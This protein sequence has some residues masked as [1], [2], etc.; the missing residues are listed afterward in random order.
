MQLIRATIAQF[1]QEPLWFR[2]LISTMLLMSIIF[3]SSSFGG[4][5]HSA[6]KLAAAILF[7]TYGIKMRRR[8]VNAIGLFALSAVCLYLSWNSLN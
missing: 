1:Q 7:A 3:S 5:Y 8:R 2:L 4:H 6:S